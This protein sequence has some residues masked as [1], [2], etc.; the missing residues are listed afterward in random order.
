MILAASVDRSTLKTNAHVLEDALHR[1][2]GLPLAQIGVCAATLSSSLSYLLGASRVLHAIARESTWP[3][4]AAL[5]PSPTLQ[6]AT[7]DS[8]SRALHPGQGRTLGN[9]QRQ[10]TGVAGASRATGGTDTAGGHG[11]QRPVRALA[12]AWG[13]AQ[14]FVIS[15][16]LKAL[17]PLV[18]DFF[19]IAACLI[20]LVG[21]LHMPHPMTGASP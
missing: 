6:T 7:P 1:A 19:L 8:P 20:N 14:L 3:P 17:A 16:D 5:A 18:T 15:G 11:H 10:S 12:L 9:G 2:S 4:L 13:L 21:C